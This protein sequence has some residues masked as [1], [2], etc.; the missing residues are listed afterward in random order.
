MD[1]DFLH[2]GAF[3]WSN[4]KYSAQFTFSR[5]A[6]GDTFHED[7]LGDTFHRNTLGATNHEDA[8]DDTTTGRE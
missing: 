2:A 6:P 7:A 4:Q 1:R 5:E 8:P 3:E